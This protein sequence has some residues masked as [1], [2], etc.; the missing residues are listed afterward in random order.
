MLHTDV[1]HEELLSANLELLYVSGQHHRTGLIAGVSRGGD[2]HG[3]AWSHGCRHGLQLAGEQGV[4]IDLEVLDSGSVK[5]DKADLIDIREGRHVIYGQDVACG[6]HLSRPDRGKG[7]GDGSR[8]IGRAKAVKEHLKPEL[9]V[10]FH[11]DVGARRT[12]GQRA[13]RHEVV[14]ED[15]IA[16]GIH[17]RGRG[18][19]EDA[20][21]SEVHGD[22]ARSDRSWG[23]AQQIH[24]VQTQL[25]SGI[26]IRSVAIH[27]PV[28][29]VCSRGENERLAD[30]NGVRRHGSTGDNGALHI[31][32]GPGAGAVSVPIVV[33]DHEVLHR[34]AG[35]ER[36]QHG[37]GQQVGAL[38]G[39]RR[40][41]AH[42][43]FVLP[44]I[45]R[46]PFAHGVLFFFLRKERRGVEDLKGDL[47]QVVVVFRTDL[48][49]LRNLDGGV[50]I[51]QEG[52]SAEH[53]IVVVVARGNV[54]QD[55]A[56]VRRGRCSRQNVISPWTGTA[57]YGIGEVPGVVSNAR[58]GRVDG[59][60]VVEVDVQSIGIDGRA[61]R[62]HFTRY[63]HLARD[64]HVARDEGG[65]QLYLGLGADHDGVGAC[66]NCGS[67]PVQGAAGIRRASHDRMGQFSVQ[68]V[69][70]ITRLVA[71]QRIAEVLIGRLV[72]EVLSFQEG[73][74]EGH[75]IVA[76]RERG[77]EGHD[78]RARSDGT[79]QHAGLDGAR[80]RIE[81]KVRKQCL[82]EFEGN[83]L[84]GEARFTVADFV[85]RVSTRSQFALFIDFQA[86]FP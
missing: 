56:V 80:G 35:V 52:G 1:V 57:P 41:F 76:S 85:A 47:G 51:Q 25:Q 55:V 34:R 65:H 7:R 18:R 63:V 28:E 53:T 44:A 78:L 15:G 6:Q 17:I 43:E 86:G 81:V 19:D 27:I 21:N 10:V 42:G 73:R 49:C 60:E 84:E 40:P 30:R 36:L 29:G 75:G 72:R 66:R 9:D 23:E 4:S 46:R 33:V 54:L 83:R 62:V 14:G 2:R 5:E 12:R 32:D 71:A 69:F 20:W 79:G 8:A 45:V 31:R 24:S 11:G 61:R 38:K 50:S 48:T 68:H 3:H 16:S 26:V 74:N 70:T 13:R 64:V 39:E 77:V 59:D 67:L 37:V 58:K 82:C 22:D